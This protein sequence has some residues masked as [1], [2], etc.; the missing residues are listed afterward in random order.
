VG[1]GAAALLNARTA[2]SSDPAALDVQAAP[3]A[4]ARRYEVRV[5]SLATSQVT[6]SRVVSPDEPSPL[7]AGAYYFKLG[8]ATGTQAIT[9]QTDDG[10]AMG[11]LLMRVTRAINAADAGVEAEVRSLPRGEA[12]LQLTATTPGA[13]GEFR[14]SGAPEGIAH[15]LEL[16]GTRAG[17]RSGGVAIPAADALFEIDGEPASASGN[18]V[19]LD[20]GR[21]RLTFHRASR[22]ALEVEVAP[23]TDALLG[24]LSA[25][26][27]QHNS[28][29]QALDAKADLLPQDPTYGVRSLAFARRDEL[30]VLGLSVDEAGRLALDP[31]KLGTMADDNGILARRGLAAIAQIAEEASQVADDL[32]DAKTGIVARSLQALGTRIAE[33]LSAQKSHIAEF[34]R[35]ATTYD[36]SGR[37]QAVADAPSLYAFYA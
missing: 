14:L 26:V 17:A 24:A 2:R 29:L 22:E 33:A 12:R 16:D 18:E 19:T 9:V 30:K 11:D 37:P 4:T 34:M 32:N 5:E 1:D 20:G 6:R 21:V 3:G 15:V 10:D 7:P 31:S 28:T 8:N 13:Q 36:P 35:L 27:S 23:D 25:F